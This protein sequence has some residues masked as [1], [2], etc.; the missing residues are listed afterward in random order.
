MA[1]YG[2][3]RKNIAFAYRS[4]RAFSSENSL[5]RLQLSKNS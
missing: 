4:S 1:T 3:V 2:E 5:K